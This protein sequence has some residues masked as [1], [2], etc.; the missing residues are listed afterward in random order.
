MTTPTTLRGVPLT[1]LRLGAP[2][3]SGSGGVAWAAT[4]EDGER[5]AVRV[6]PDVTPTAHAARE[7]RLEI[8]RSLDHPGLAPV[9]TMAGHVDDRLVVTDLV[10]GPTLATV[11]AGRMGLPAAESLTLA[12][13]LASAI[14][15]LHRHG[16]VHGDVAPS[17]VV[18]VERESDGAGRPVLVDLLADLAGEAGTPGFVAPEVRE[19]R[20]ASPAADVWALAT[21]CVWATRVGERELV[22]RALGPATSADPQARP[23][24]A[25]LVAHLADQATTPVQVPPPSVLAGA[26]LREHA[27]RAPTVLRPA[28][29]RRARHRRAAPVRSAAVAML[30]AVAVGLSLWLLGTGEQG[31]PSAHAR[32]AVDETAAPITEVVTDLVAARDAALVA[33]DA[34]ALA[35][36]TVEGSPAR[37]DDA[38]LLAALGDTQLSGLQTAV[39]DVA[40]LEATETAAQVRAVLAQGAHE[41]TSGGATETVPAQQPRC[42]VLQLRLD[43]PRWAVERVSA[44]G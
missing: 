14:A 34:A 30:V 23:S 24:A 39:A 19:G 20:A 6:L 36:V 40:V 10:P 26:A 2:L 22:T 44:C 37:A 31:E 43:G 29:R 21:T 9:R 13:G 27:Q 28:R 12:H 15:E 25:W 18:L 11:R 33:A 41:R 4:T 35:A 5:V 1:G 8:L 17:N 7:R 32:S 16:L 42:V 3:G 38:A